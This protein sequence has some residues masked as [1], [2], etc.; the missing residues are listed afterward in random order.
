MPLDIAARRNQAL[1]IG[2]SCAACER[3]CMQQLFPQTQFGLDVLDIVVRA[4]F[5]QFRRRIGC[6]LE[7]AEMIHQADALRIDS[8]PH[9]ALRDLVHLFDGFLPAVGDAPQELLV[10]MIDRRLQDLLGDGPKRSVEAHVAGQ[11]RGA[12]A[13]DLDAEFLQACAETSGC[14][15]IRR[16]I[17]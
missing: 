3:I 1:P 16:S 9:P 5:G 15:K 11:R 7:S 2:R 12:D 6:V 4:Q 14:R 8:R 13:V 10:G 17:R